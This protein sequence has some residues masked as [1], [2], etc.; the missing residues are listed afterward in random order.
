MKGFKDSTRTQSGHNF[1]R[2]STPVKPHSRAMPMKKAEGGDDRVRLMREDERGN[3]DVL[4]KKG[5]SESEAINMATNPAGR[6]SEPKEYAK[7]GRV[8]GSKRG[9]P[10]FSSKPKIGC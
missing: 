2:T 4:R 1:T 3:Y 6:L 5:F 9:T 10:T 7:G 8:T